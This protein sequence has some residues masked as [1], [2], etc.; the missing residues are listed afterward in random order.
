MICR[1]GQVAVAIDKLKDLLN[2]R[3]AAIRGQDNRPAQIGVLRFQLGQAGKLGA[4]NRDLNIPKT[5]QFPQQQ[6]GFIGLGIEGVLGPQL[7]R[8]AAQGWT[9]RL[10]VDDPRRQGRKAEIIAKSVIIR[11]GQRGKVQAGHIVKIVTDD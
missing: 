2:V 1:N 3:L 9:L 4:I 8:P 5:L 7:H 6:A 10:K 11:H